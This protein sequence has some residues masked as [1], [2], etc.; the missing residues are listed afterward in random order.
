MSPTDFVVTIHALE[1]M[2]ERFPQLVEKMSDTGQAELIHKEVM[3]ALDSGRH[4]MVPPLE[5]AARATDRWEHRRQGGYVA[6]TQDKGRGYVLQEHAEE[7]LIVLTVLT[8]EG[9]EEAQG[10]RRAWK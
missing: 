10:R 2:E 5:L 3:D 7:G 9:R 4:G 8:G 1:R 6:W